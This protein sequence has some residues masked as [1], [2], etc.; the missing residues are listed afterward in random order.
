MA[1]TH[2]TTANTAT[3]VTAITPEDVVTTQATGKEWKIVQLIGGL[4]MI[5]GVVSCS[6]GSAHNGGMIFFLGCVVFLGGR[7][8]AW[9]NH[10]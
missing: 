5:G 3:P 6:G 8:G 9:W 1:T 4:L 7:I 2:P 10:G